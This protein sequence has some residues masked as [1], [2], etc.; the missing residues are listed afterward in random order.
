MG[1]FAIPQ[2]VLRYGRDMNA[3]LIERCCSSKVLYIGQA[4]CTIDSAYSPRGH[5][6]FVL[7]MQSPSGYAASALA[8]SSYSV[9]IA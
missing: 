4:G 6:T 1:L 7:H 3:S 5:S 9:N 2:A 8:L